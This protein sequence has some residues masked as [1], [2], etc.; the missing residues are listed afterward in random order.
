MK[1]IKTYIN[2]LLHPTDYS[3]EA[4]ISHLRKSGVKIG[5]QCYIYSPQTVKIDASRPYLLEIGDQVVFTRGVTILTHDYSHTVMRK[6][7]GI[8]HGDAKSVKIGNNVFFG[9]DSLILMGTT[10]GNNV[11]IGAKS[12]VRGTIPDNVVVAGNPAR[13]VATLDEYYEKRKARELDCAKEN[14]RL[15]IERLG[16]T[17]TIKE[18]GD[19][20]AWLYLP[21]NE[22]TITQHRGFFHLS[23]DDHES[24][25]SEFMKS[26]PMFESYEKFLEWAISD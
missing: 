5:K 26:T 1:F 13:I 12:V 15:C 22:Q 9:M 7:Y 11:I 3:S 14:V 24:L 23:G 16:R 18:M 21:R 17:P 8:Q 2:K 4:Y 25:V 20:F 10:I 19:A 6:K